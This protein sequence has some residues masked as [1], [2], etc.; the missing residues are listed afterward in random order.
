MKTEEQIEREKQ[1]RTERITTPITPETVEEARQALLRHYC[2]GL[3][4][5]EINALTILQ[6]YSGHTPDEFAE[7]VMKHYTPLIAALANVAHGML[8]YIE[9]INKRIGKLEGEDAR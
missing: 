6:S 1:E 8:S 5:I 4:E 3:N 9:K 7:D 2:G